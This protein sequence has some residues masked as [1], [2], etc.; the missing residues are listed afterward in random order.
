MI[1][2]HQLFSQFDGML[3]APPRPGV[4]LRQASIRGVSR[5]AVALAAM[6]APAMA[7]QTSGA[8]PA[9]GQSQS[10]ATVDPTS[11]A[12]RSSGSGGAWP[13]AQEATRRRRNTR[14]GRCAAFSGDIVVTAQRRS[15]R[16][17]D[18]PIAVS[19]VGGGTLSSQN[20]T[21]SRDLAAGHSRGWWPIRRARHPSLTF[22]VSALTCQFRAPSRRS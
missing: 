2:S 3:A 21:S 12:A 15:Q 6:Q 5:L 14:R 9:A 7:Q 1:M 13:P 16:L 19:V 20:I 11:D 10:A 17:Q 8:V 22:A 4:A 18:V